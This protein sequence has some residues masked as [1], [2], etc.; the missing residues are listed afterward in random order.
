VP[1]GVDSGSDR[2]AR[3]TGVDPCGAQ[4]ARTQ[5]AQGPGGAIER[6]ITPGEIHRTA[7]PAEIRVVEGVGE[8][9]EAVERGPQR[10]GLHLERAREFL[11]LG[12]RMA[13]ACVGHR[14][15]ER[16]LAVAPQ[17]NP[18]EDQ[19]RVSEFL[20]GVTECQRLRQGWLV[21]RDG[22]WGPDLP[23]IT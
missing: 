8:R 5:R 12:T 20:G 4:R 16:G 22:R 6:G 9:V 21:Q 17:E 3:G 1:G 11:G 15:S 7:A 23:V 10:V 19:S 13:P 18:V 2:G 14:R